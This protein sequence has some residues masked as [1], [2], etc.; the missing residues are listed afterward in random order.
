MRAQIEFQGSR[1]G[2]PVMMEQKPEV[3]RAFACDPQSL[4]EYAQ[5]VY[6]ST[7]QFLDGLAPADLDR[8]M[9]MSSVWMPSMGHRSWTSNP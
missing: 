2:L 1:L 3:V 7:E 5:A 9:D 8:V 4:Q 6:A